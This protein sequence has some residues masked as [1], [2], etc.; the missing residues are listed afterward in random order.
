MGL[1]DGIANKL[2]YLTKDSTEQKLKDELTK[3]RQ[4][5]EKQTA[6]GFGAGS[7]YQYGSIS[8]RGLGSLV[9]SGFSNN[10]AILTEFW[11]SPL[12]GQ[13]RLVDLK[14]VK[15][16]A[17]HGI[18]SM[19]VEKILDI[20]AQ[21]QW[22]IQ[23]KRGEE[24]NQQH[25]DEILEFF[26]N[27]NRN[28]ETTD[29]IIRKVGRNILETDDGTIVKVFD[30]YEEI[31]PP[32]YYGEIVPQHNTRTST[33]Y[34]ADKIP[35]E[36]AQMIEMYA[37]DGTSFLIQSDMH[38]SILN[39]WQYS[40]II[41]RRPI[42]FIPREICYI[43]QNSH[44]GSLYGI[45]PFEAIVDYLQFIILAG[46]YNQRFYEN[47]SYPAFQLDL[48]NVKTQA[49]IEAWAEWFRKNYMGH[50]K[51]WQ[52]LITN[53]G[54]K[55]TPLTFD[56]K[57]LQNLESQQWFVDLILA[58]LKVPKAL[59]GIPEGTN[60][61]TMGGQV[62][63]F[64]TQAINPLKKIIAAEINKHIIPELDPDGCC[65]FI[66]LQKTD[67]DEETKR[68]AIYAAYLQNSVYT[69]NEVRVELDKEAIKDESMDMTLYQRQEKRQEELMAQ[70]T[71][72][73]NLQ[74]QSSK[75]PPPSQ[76]PSFQGNEPEEKA[77][78]YLG[79]CAM[80]AEPVYSDTVLKHADHQVMRDGQFI[81]LSKIFHSKHS[82]N[83]EEENEIK[84]KR[85]ERDSIIQSE[86]KKATAY[87]QLI[88]L[89]KKLEEEHDKKR[90]V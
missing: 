10:K 9:E 75:K 11:V 58:K 29:S 32:Q 85:D 6:N 33:G 45:S 67:L 71:V 44:P 39:Y 83:E 24:K 5:L 82:R 3:Q 1:L 2:G 84:L 90:D 12:Y 30:K 69:P 17:R 16:L 79:V 43:K 20:I 66:F 34:P 22:T 18:G 41:P 63:M 52:A 55:V 68:S 57:A 81:D 49:D 73:Q 65:E 87:N 35:T 54:A 28:N 4:E 78:E 7:F 42:K 56:N 23:A 59:L 40:F 46:K 21:E 74:A 76:S 61:A 13:P 60:R 72:E 62:A 50:E 51:S 37:E 15:M 86:R 36:N 31:Q 80:D 47:S 64:K 89:M 26:H 77:R 53:G 14:T 27:P 19:A 25:I 88:N 38:G 70:Q 48:P 8:T